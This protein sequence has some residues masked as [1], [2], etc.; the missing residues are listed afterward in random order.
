MVAATNT[1]QYVYKDNS[2]QPLTPFEVKVG[3]CNNKGDGAFSPVTVIYSAEGEPVWAPTNITATSLS[4]SHIL[5][6]WYSLSDRFPKP[7][8][9]QVSAWKN[10]EQSK[11]TVSISGNDSSALVSGLEGNTDYL[12]TVRAYNNAG[13]GPPSIPM[14]VTT[15]KSPPSQAPFNILWHKDGSALTLDWEPV[16]SRDNESEVMGY[17]VL[18]RHEGDSESEVIET[19]DPSAV[20]PLGKDNVYIIEVRAVS[21]GGDG[22]ISSQIRIPKSAVEQT[23]SVSPVAEMSLEEQ[24][25]IDLISTKDTMRSDDDN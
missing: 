7:H 15:K 5:V 6:S 13:L 22:T 10:S 17:K 12:V 18:Y 3:V 19:R 24:I 14:A 2:L 11:Q 8:G 25:F 20:I 4:A 23:R 16:R 9:Y 1:C 21:E